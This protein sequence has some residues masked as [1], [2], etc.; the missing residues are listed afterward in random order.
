M[1]AG[2]GAKK[3]PPHPGPGSGYIAYCEGGRFEGQRGRAQAFDADGKEIK[4]FRGTSGMGLH[5]QNFI[6]AVLS[7]DASSLNTDVEVGNDSTGWCNLA[8]YRVFKL[9][10]TIRRR[11][12]NRS[13]KRF[14]IGES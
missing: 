13:A 3:S 12:L 4:S 11:R 9:G 7:R 6:D 14:R 10:K 1:A 8:K 2:P 5:Q